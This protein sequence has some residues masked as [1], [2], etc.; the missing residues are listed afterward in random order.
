MLKII[1]LLLL[2]IVAFGQ[3]EAD[4]INILA[5]HLNAKKEVRMYGGRADLVTSTHAIE[6]E[7][8]KNWKNSV[9]QCLWYAQQLNLR[10]GVILIMSDKKDFK[11]VQM[12]QSTLNYA[13]LE[14]R[15]ALWV[16]PIDFPKE[17]RLRTDD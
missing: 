4:Y 6:V 7:R 15:V 17:V 12:L 11:Y 13:G 1:L 5:Q 14:D 2:P 8:A 10:P 16:Y 9:G 3:K